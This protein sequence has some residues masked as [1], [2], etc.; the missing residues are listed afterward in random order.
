MNIPIKA[1]IALVLAIVLAGG[2]A[3]YVHIQDVKTCNAKL[4]EQ[5]DG[6]N[7]AFAK[8]QSESAAQLA[9]INQRSSALVA[10]NEKL[11]SAINEH[12]THT[13]TVIQHAPPDKCTDARVPDVILNVLREPPRD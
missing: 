2:P 10:E 12:T 13:I 5:A 8:A 9:E 7:A 4:K 6:Y 3:L 1:I 11:K